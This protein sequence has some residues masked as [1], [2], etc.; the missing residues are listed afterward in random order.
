MSAGHALGCAEFT[1]G[2]KV[3]TF[4]SYIPQTD[5]FNKGGFIYFADIFTSP[6]SFFLIGILL[7]DLVLLSG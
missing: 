7:S 6:S 5:T 2:G 3:K 1:S 4:T